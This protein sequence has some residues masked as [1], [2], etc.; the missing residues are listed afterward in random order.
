MKWLKNVLIISLLACLISTSFAEGDTLKIR[1]NNE[2]IR[3]DVAPFITNGTTYVPIRFISEGLNIT[4]ISWNNDSKSVTIKKDSDTLRILINK[5]YA[6]KNGTLISVPSPALIIN[7]RT[8]VPLRFVSENLNANVEWQ[9]STN[10]VLITTRSQTSN[11]SNSQ[12]KPNSSNGATSSGSIT[13]PSK[14]NS[15]S[16]STPNSTLYT[17]YDDA[18]YWL[19][20]IIEAEASG[21]PLKGKVAVG[22]VILNRVRSDEFPNT[23][24]SVIFDTK[25]GIQ[26]EPVANGSIYNTP[27]ADSIKAAKIA[28]EGSNYIGKCLYFM[29]PAIAQ[30]NW[31]SKNR[32]HYTTI[33]N[34][35]FYL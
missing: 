27:S 22:E 25:F 3:T 10:T 14:P 26:F 6:Y 8:F 13:S 31:I 1:V 28:L 2:Y 34:H 19:S 33:G 12:S 32:V 21:E 9:E 7:D 24:W 17:N 16:S 5:N 11:G 18:I 30:S 29:N 4:N 20:R 23:I 15:S 35:E